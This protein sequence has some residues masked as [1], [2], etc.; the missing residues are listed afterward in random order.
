MTVDWAAWDAIAWAAAEGFLALL[1]EDDFF[2]GII[3]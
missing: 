3:D 1:A 2:T